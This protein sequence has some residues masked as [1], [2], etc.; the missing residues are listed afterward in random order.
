MAKTR[1]PTRGLPFHQGL[2]PE[3]R[4]LLSREARHVDC[5]ASD[6]ILR[7][8]QKAS[9]AYMVLRG[10][11]R[12]YS[13]SADGNEATLYWIE[14]G[15][16]CI[17]ALNCLFNNLLYPAWVQA[18]VETEVAVIPG[19]VYRRLFAQ[20]ASVQNLT[21]EAL[22]TLVFRLMEQLQQLHGKNNRQRLASLLL[23]RASAQGELRITQLQ[24]AQHLGT[25]RE[26]V[27]RLLLEFADHGYLATG[28]GRLTLLDTDGLRA[29]SSPD[30]A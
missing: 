27:A 6:V 23:T 2:S 7:Q 14:P 24:L 19:R 18:E 3:G 11:L 8:G 17:L 1:D 12:V 28:R 26:V 13:V 4:E 21:V 10:R 9:G 5:D 25:R 15:E 20:E 30:G 16:T 29:V 22:S